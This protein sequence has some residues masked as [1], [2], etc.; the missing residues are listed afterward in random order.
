MAKNTGKV[1]E[2]SGNFVSP[3]KC[4]PWMKQQQDLTLFWPNLESIKNIW[5]MNIEESRESPWKPEITR[6]LHILVGKCKG[7]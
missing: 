1:Q 5:K 6:S 2:K 3:E 7:N 4:E